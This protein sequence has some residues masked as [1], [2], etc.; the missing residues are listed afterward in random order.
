[1]S[2]IVPYFIKITV[3]E[4]S[5]NEDYR[6][7]LEWADKSEMQLYE[8]RGY[9]STPVTACNCAW[10]RFNEDHWYYSDPLGAWE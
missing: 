9:G 8:I 7:F 2:E 3:Q 1:M 10:E 6:A 5:K 4:K